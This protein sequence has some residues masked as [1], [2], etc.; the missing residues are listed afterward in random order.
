MANTSRWRGEELPDKIGTVKLK[1][2][3]T[4]LAMQEHLVWGKLP[5]NAPMSPG[6]TVLVE[7]TSS[8]SMPRNIT[9]GRVVT[10][11][12]G[13]RWVPMKVTNLSD[14]PVTLK[15][16][17]KLADVSPCLAVEDFELLQGYSQIDTAVPGPRHTPLSASGLE[18]RLRDVGLDNLDIR[19]CQTSPAGTGK[20]SSCSNV[21][22]MSFP[23][24][25]W[26]VVRQRALSAAFD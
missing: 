16:N 21:T 24:T 4:L 5:Y 14:R 13:D 6:S 23:S 18:Q 17:C 2:S 1:Q 26:T 7:P 19:P 8:K 20:L 15:R 9:V 10:P 22:T 3:V 12:W 25:K 11:L